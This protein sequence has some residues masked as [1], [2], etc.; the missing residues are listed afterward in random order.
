MLSSKGV[1]V[2]P[3]ATT[4]TVMLYGASSHASARVKPWTPD[5]AAQ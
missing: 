3:G 2:A 1:S 5:F 4:L